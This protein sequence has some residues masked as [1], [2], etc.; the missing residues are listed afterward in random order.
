MGWIFVI[1]FIGLVWVKA[2]ETYHGYH[3]KRNVSRRTLTPRPP[4]VRKKK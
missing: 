3:A 4:K 1:L 2:S